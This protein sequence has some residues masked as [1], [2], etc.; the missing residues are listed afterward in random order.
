MRN[1][2]ANWCKPRRLFKIKPPFCNSLPPSGFTLG[3]LSFAGFSFSG[4]IHLLRLS[5]ESFFNKGLMF[6]TETQFQSLRLNPPFIECYSQTVHDKTVRCRLEVSVMIERRNRT[7]KGQC[8]FLH[9]LVLLTLVFKL[10]IP[11]R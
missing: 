9:N 7:R 4:L 5:F 3:L 1:Q 11:I 8:E 2:I 6:R 10:F